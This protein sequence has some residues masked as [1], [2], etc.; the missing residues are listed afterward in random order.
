MRRIGLLS[1]VVVLLLCAALAGAVECKPRTPKA[2][3][4]KGTFNP[5][6]FGEGGGLGTVTPDQ[7][8]CWE[9]I[10][11]QQ[12]GEGVA[13][14][15]AQPNDGTSPA[16]E[17]PAEETETPQEGDAGIVQPPVLPPG[18]PV[19]EPVFEKD[20][21]IR[22]APGDVRNIPRR[23]PGPRRS[24]P[25]NSA[26]AAPSDIVGQDEELR[27]A[28][29]SAVQ[30]SLWNN[31]STPLLLPAADTGS[32]S[33]DQ[34]KSLGRRDYEQHI[35]A[36]GMPERRASAVA[37]EHVLEGRFT[38]AVE[39][40][41]PNIQDRVPIVVELDVRTA[42]G[43]FRDAV[44]GLSAVSGFSRDERFAPRFLGAKQ[45]RVAVRGWIHP[46]QFTDVMARPEVLRVE[47]DRAVAKAASALERGFT[48]ILVGVRIP[49]ESSPTEALKLAVARLSESAGFELKKTIG[50]QRIPGTSKMVL[51]V[52][53]RVP[54]R[55]LS[56][57]MA[58]PAV[59][60]V[61]PAPGSAAPPP[62][63]AS[64]AWLDAPLRWAGNPVLW[65][66]LTMLGIMIFLQL[67]LRRRSR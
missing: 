35:L 64:P 58:D 21:R 26:V 2:P 65:V 66:L 42:P 48:E 6:F 61:A 57:V 24:S 44:A 54:V 47:Q 46:R 12:G 31:L 40:E 10:S 14:I 18:G 13:D 3:V 4:K 15:P 38:P 51:I 67:R 52:S 23:W 43:D 8:D 19:V 1:S 27:D 63:A 11:R 37:G 16:S 39:V 17:V 33:M 45:E 28:P 5:L 22:Y 49:P 30:Y 56:R 36:A 41:A 53:G 34:A 50:Y 9:T 32:I 29:A 25:Q 60:K 62:V 55:R 7:S 59:V 20:V